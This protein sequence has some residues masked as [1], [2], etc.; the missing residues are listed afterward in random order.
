MD[1]FVF[2]SNPVM[3]QTKFIF[4]QWNPFREQK[5]GVLDSQERLAYYRP[6]A[7]MALNFSYATFKNNY[8]QYHL[9][10]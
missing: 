4:S 3:S 1:D 6:L 5:L 8:W 7:H 2:L 9:R 10:K